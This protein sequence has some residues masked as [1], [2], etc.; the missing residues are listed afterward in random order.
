[1]VLN[2]YRFQKHAWSHAWS[3]E[4]TDVSI[5]TIVALAKQKQRKWCLVSKILLWRPCI[6]DA[7]I[8]F[9]SCG[10]FFFPRLISAVGDWNGCLPYFHTWCSLS[11]NL[12][13]RYETRCARLAEIQDAKNVE[14]SPSGHHPTICRAISL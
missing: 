5:N 13:C 9:S 8:I 10:F 1:M 14:K 11:A 7:D 3:M 12:E 4:L 2:V 6:A